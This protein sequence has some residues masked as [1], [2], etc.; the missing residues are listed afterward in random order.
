MRSPKRS[1]GSC[2]RIPRLDLRYSAVL[3]STVAILVSAN[4]VRAQASSGYQP[5]GQANRPFDS[6]DA[7]FPHNPALERKLERAREAERQKRI[8]EETQKLLSL[9]L[10]YRE[11]TAGKEALTDDQRS[12][13]VQIEKL[14]R[15]IRN[16]MRGAE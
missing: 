8:V 9:T 7:D 11:A 16:R 2:S 4:V 10:Q 3:L 6:R 14:A 12:M 15:D 1:K 5:P 13:L